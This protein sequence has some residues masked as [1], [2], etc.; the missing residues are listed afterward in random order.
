MNFAV[1]WDNLPYLLL[2]AWP[3]APLGGAALTLVLSVLSG[4]VAA[5]IGLVLGVMLALLHNRRL[6]RAMLVMLAFFRAIPVLLLIFWI[7]FLLPVAF[8]LDVP[9][10]LTV[11]VALSLVGGAYLAHSVY[12][13]IQSLATGQWQAGAALGMTRWQV[14]HLVLLPQALPMMAPSFINQWVSLIKDTSLAYVIGVAELS[15]V[16]TQVSNRVMVYPAEIF[17]AVALIYYL[18]C[19]SLDVTAGWVG[20]RYAHIWQV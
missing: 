9:K 10:L 18:F 13:G 15:F 1:V 5:V 17:L 20:R 3:D 14:L 19:A 8:G 16:A 4:T 12:S 2:G 11:V 6:H 7:Y